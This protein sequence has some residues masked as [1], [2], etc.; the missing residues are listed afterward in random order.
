MIWMSL[1]RRDCKA[2]PAG[3]NEDNN[4]ELPGIG[5][6]P[7]SSWTPGSPGAGGPRCVVHSRDI[8]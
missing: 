4:M 8:A 2:S 7:G 6:W 3:K 5:E 1:V